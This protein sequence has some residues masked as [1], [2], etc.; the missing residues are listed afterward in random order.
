MAVLDIVIEILRIN[1]SYVDCN[2]PN[3]MEGIFNLVFFPSVFIILLIFM[4]VGFVTGRTGI[5]ENKMIQLLLSI[6]FF[7]FIIFQDLYTM[8]VNL[9]TVWYF[10]VILLVGIWLILRIF[11]G[12]AKE[13]GTRGAMLDKVVSV[14]ERLGFENPKE[15]PFMIGEHIQRR[16][17][18]KG[19]IKLLEKER[20]ALE[21]ADVG[22]RKTTYDDKI[23]RL[24]DELE[25]VESALGYLKKARKPVPEAA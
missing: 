8:F 25:R 15:L 11:F 1:C 19:R 7:A 6:A 10:A 20:D 13:G 22:R 12:P 16:N 9:S 3:V 18:L 17:E 2:Y 24:K 4:L 14:R 21:G 23:G 5:T